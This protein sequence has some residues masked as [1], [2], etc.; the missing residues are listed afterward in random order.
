MLRARMMMLIIIVTAIAPS[1][2]NVVAALVL[3]GLRNAGTPLEIASTPV[4]AAHPEENARASRK[5]IAAW[6]ISPP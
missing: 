2:S 6:E 1:I 3:L 5:I 4:R